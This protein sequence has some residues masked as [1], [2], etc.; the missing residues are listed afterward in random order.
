MFKLSKSHNWLIFRII[1]PEIKKRLESY[2]S[3]KLIDIGCG[4]KPYK[5]M[6]SAY[7][8]EHVGVDHKESLHDKSN[9]DLIG[10][11]YKIPSDDNC[12]DTALCTDV[13]EHLED[14]QKAV[15]EAY[16]VLKKGGYAIYTVPF[17]W[18]V[19]EQPRDFYRYTKYGL[20]YIFKEAGFEIVEIKPLS[21]FIVMMSQLLVYFLYK[22][23][24]GGKINPLWWIIPLVGHCIQAVA[25]C[26]NRFDNSEEFTI[27]YIVVVKKRENNS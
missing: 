19:H 25:Y 2:A 1:N 8:T 11:A 12:F 22:F 6:A 5:E 27:E 24:R 3:G 10:T 16:R 20:K 14:P 7:V 9:V 17:F 18:H 13:L 26:L 15:S 23:R 21:G 4:I